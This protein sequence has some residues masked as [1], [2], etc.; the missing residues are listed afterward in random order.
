[1]VFGQLSEEMVMDS[2][3]ESDREI[4]NNPTDGLDDDE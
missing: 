2:L 4:E 1:M 3:S